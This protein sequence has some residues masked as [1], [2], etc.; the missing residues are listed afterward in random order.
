MANLSNG[1]HPSNLAQGLPG[2]SAGNS[3]PNITAQL[4]AQMAAAQLNAANKTALDSAEAWKKF[5]EALEKVYSEPVN[6]KT[7]FTFDNYGSLFADREVVS[8]DKDHVKL[9]CSSS[10]NEVIYTKSA[11]IHNDFD[12][13]L[14]PS[15][16]QQCVM[17]MLTH[18][19]ISREGATINLCPEKRALIEAMQEEM[20]LTEPKIHNPLDVND[21]KGT[22]TNAQLLSNARA[23]AKQYIAAQQ[24]ASAAATAS[25]TPTGAPAGTTPPQA[26]RKAATSTVGGAS[27]EQLTKASSISGSYNLN[28]D[29]PKEPKAAQTSAE[30]S[31]ATQ[32]MEAAFGKEL[33]LPIRTVIAQVITTPTGENPTL[34]QIDAAFE[35]FAENYPTTTA[36]Q[37]TRDFVRNVSEKLA[38]YMVSVDEIIDCYK[39]GDINYTANLFTNRM[40]EVQNAQPAAN[41]SARAPMAVQIDTPQKQGMIKRPFETVKK[42]KTIDPGKAYDDIDVPIIGLKHFENLTTALRRDFPNELKLVEGEDITLQKYQ[43]VWDKLSPEQQK[44]MFNE[45]DPKQLERQVLATQQPDPETVATSEAPLQIEEPENID[46]ADDAEAEKIKAI[47]DRDFS[48]R[49]PEGTKDGLS[50]EQYIDVWKNKLSQEERDDILAK[51]D[52]ETIAAQRLEQQQREGEERTGIKVDANPRNLSPEELAS[53]Q[54]AMKEFSTASSSEAK[55]E[56]PATVNNGPQAARPPIAARPA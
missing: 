32:K 50:D 14:T 17:D 4:S 40:H 36:D 19:E 56:A 13:T 2:F 38:P 15:E 22:P 42:V 44:S 52:P 30:P 6:L 46:Y 21:L 9:I 31:A 1:Q 48:E 5:I 45:T 43:A 23:Q 39:R 18:P 12:G 25:A 3:A 7:H 53:A 47:L 27:S 41:A 20:G 10:G 28:L 37:N 29:T 8:A 11:I 16:A 54:K 49:L 35:Y 55:G 26:A 24:A 34:Q 33:S 51:T